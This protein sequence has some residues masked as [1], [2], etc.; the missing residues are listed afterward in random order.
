MYLNVF[1]IIFLHYDGHSTLWEKNCSLTQRSLGQHSACLSAVP[2]T[3]AV[4]LPK[5]NYAHFSEAAG[6]ILLIFSCRFFISR[7]ES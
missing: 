3:V 1:I 4:S 6:L 2:H 5:E 7:R